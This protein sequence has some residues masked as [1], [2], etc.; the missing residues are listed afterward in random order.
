MITITPTIRN[1]C[2]CQSCKKTYSY[3]DVYEEK[4]SRLKT[5]YF[6]CSDRCFFK[7]CYKIISKYDYELLVD[8]YFYFSNG[9]IEE[10][11]TKLLKLS[12]NDLIFEDTKYYTNMLLSSIK[13]EVTHTQN[14][15]SR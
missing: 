2:T 8:V 3:G 15:M 12:K 4:V 14:S 11:Y 7:V 1:D 6:V 13:Q 5:H 10:I 9:K